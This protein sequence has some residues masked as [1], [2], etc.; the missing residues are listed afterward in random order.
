[1]SVGAFAGVDGEQEREV[2]VVAVEQ[3][4]LPQ[5]VDVVARYCRKQCIELVV[6]LIEERTVGVRKDG[7][8]LSHLASHGW[9]VPAIEHDRERKVAHALAFAQSA[10]AIA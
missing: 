1:M 10:Q 8:E 7:S 9:Q 6:G 2:G 3:E 4:Q 5:I